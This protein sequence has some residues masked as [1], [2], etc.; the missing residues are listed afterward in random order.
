MYC[1]HCGK[2]FDERAIEKK[3]S[4][5]VLKD[6][7]GELLEID[8]EAKIEY[9]CPQCGHLAHLDLNE[10]EYKSLSRAAHSQLQ[11]GANSFARGMALNLIGIIIGVLALSFFLLSYTSSGGGKTLDTGKSTFIVFV[12]MAVVAVILLGFGIY[13]TIIGVSKKTMYTKLLKDLNNKTFVQ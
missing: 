6:E 5:Y 12:V 10:E 9:V 4:S 11:R 7:N 2:K 1:S 8:S 3:Q 13:S